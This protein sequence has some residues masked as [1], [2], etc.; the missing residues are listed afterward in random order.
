MK[1]V[2]L[3]FAGLILIVFAGMFHI[4]RYG[5]SESKKIPPPPPE[6]VAMPKITG[7][8]ADPALPDDTAAPLSDD[9]VPAKSSDEKIPA[10]TINAD[11]KDVHVSNTDIHDT[12]RM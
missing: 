11:V 8:S 3:F 6:V 2:S 1:N 7:P 10:P 5:M 4:Y 12:T 9:D